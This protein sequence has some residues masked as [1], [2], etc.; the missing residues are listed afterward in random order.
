MDR[1]QLIEGYHDAWTTGDIA[2]AR[3]CLAEDLD[4]RGSIDT[5]TKADKFVAALAQSQR[6]LRG[7]TVLESFFSKAGAALLYFVFVTKSIVA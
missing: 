5:F 6:M 3:S 7:V 2:R 1:R 4:F